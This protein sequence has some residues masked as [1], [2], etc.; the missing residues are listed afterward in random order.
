MAE[1]VDA[2]IDKYHATLFVNIGLQNGVLLRTVLDPLTGSLGDT[3]TRFLGSRPVKL[4]RV[5][6]Q[7]QPAILAL[8]SRPWLNYAY[9]GILQFTPLIFDALD[10]AWSFSAELCPEGLIGIV[11]N[12]LR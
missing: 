1:I 4:A 8:S 10:Y 2:S 3:R 5:P 6:V 11:G 9:R 12:S 7:G